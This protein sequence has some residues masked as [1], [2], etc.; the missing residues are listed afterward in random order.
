MI[1]DAVPDRARAGAR[2]IVRHCG[3]LA[4]DEP[5]LVIGSE[6][7][8]AVAH[9]LAAEA[10][11]TGARVTE[12][13]I[14]P[15]PMH[16]TEPPPAVAEA[17][18]RARLIIAATSKS[19][20]HTTARVNAAAAGA[21]FLSMPDFSLDL[22]AAEDVMVDYM[23]L[24]GAVR[25]VADRLAGARDLRVSSRQGTRMS[26]QAEG[27]VGNCCPGYVRG[28]GDL[29]SPP[30]IEANVSPIETA[31]E[32]RI[33]V[34]GSI[35]HP[36]IGVLA[37]PVT[38]WV[39]GGFLREWEGP[40]SVLDALSALFAGRSDK[41]KVL[42][43]CGLGMNPKARLRGLMLTDEGCAGGVHFGFGSNATVGGLNAVDFHLD[44][45][46]REATLTVD[47]EAVLEDGIFAPWVGF[48]QP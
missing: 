41:A 16:G 9:L 1:H 40:G 32:G 12:M 47:G 34:D 39:E 35:A 15:A 10:R 27:R 26:L 24:H 2:H 36:S 19:L 4:E 22:L 29:G 11:A 8:V 28:P 23:A 20:A 46:T 14:P 25:R 48:P 3:G 44:F 5:V 31:S 6:D 43:E 21:R 42:A 30:D 45:C 18:L 17:M 37:E 7:A 33:V 13:V 38:L